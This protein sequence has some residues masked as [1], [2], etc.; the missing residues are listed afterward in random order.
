MFENVKADI[1]R[2]IKTDR[3]Q[4]ARGMIN[5][6]FS[7]YSLWVVLSY[8][9]GRW[10][11]LNFK[12]P[13]IKSILKLISKVIHGILCLLTGI[14]IKFETKIGPGLYVGHSGMLIINAKAV[15]GEN[16]NIGVGVVI[17]QAGRGARKGSPVIGDRVYIAVGAKVIGKIKIG[18]DVAIGANAVVT[19]DVPNGVTVAGVPAKIIK[20]EGSQEF[21]E[22]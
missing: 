6:F 3:I 17:G 21:I 22:Y 7:E 16:C 13:V 11:R 18:N 4:T 1:T 2:Y 12:I 9:C 20:Q 5:L 15:I 14:N 19:K 8:R 10:I